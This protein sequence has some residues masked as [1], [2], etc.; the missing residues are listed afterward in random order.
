MK[1][2]V[3]EVYETYFGSIVKV[4]Y[5]NKHSPKIVV[6]YDRESGRSIFCI[7]YNYNSKKCK[8]C[9][10]SKYRQCISKY[11]LKRKLS[12]IEKVLLSKF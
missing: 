9:C 10:M 12:K 7:D 4:I 5:I 6:E 1:I 3:G 2:K 8:I 11:I